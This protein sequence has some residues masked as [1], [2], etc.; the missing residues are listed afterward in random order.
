MRRAL[1][2][3]HVVG[4]ICLLFALCYL[5]SSRSIV[6]SSFGDTLGPRMFPQILGALLALLAVGM[7]IK[8]EPRRA[9]D[10]LPRGAVIAIIATVI[11][12]ALFALLLPLIGFAPTTF[13][14]TLAFSLS[15]REKLL[16]S[17]GYGI[18]LAAIF[19]VVFVILLAT[20]FPQATWAGLI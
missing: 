14:I 13:L 6:E 9:A 12:V 4:V 3:D 8:A 7:I 16:V 5:W 15:L 11:M 17:V 19:Y 18:L 10:A 2:I 1:G 20:P